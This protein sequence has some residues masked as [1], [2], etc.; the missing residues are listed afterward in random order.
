MI[1]ISLLVLIQFTIIQFGFCCRC[2][3]PYEPDFYANIGFNSKLCLVVYEGE[4]SNSNTYHSLGE[5]KLLNAISEFE[6]EIGESIYSYAGDG[7]NCGLMLEELTVGD[8]LF[9][10]L[11]GPF[12]DTTDAYDEYRLIETC[13][14]HYLKVEDGMSGGNTVE[15]II[16]ILSN[17]TGS[18]DVISTSEYID[19]FPN[20]VDDVVTISANRNNIAQ[21]Q[22]YNAQGSVIADNLNVN[23]NEIQID[24]GDL[25]TGLYFLV[26]TIGE[27]RH[28][29]KVLKK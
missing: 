27:E 12:G 22:L 14:R 17:W 3:G 20:P 4:T 8:T 24:L 2:D 5:F 21:F 29:K 28:V 26:V 19:L 9:L 1:R 6:Q 11:Y 13:G 16:E 10:I 18:G 23:S 7:G 15:E 25:E